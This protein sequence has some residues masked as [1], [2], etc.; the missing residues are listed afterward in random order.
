MFMFVSITSRCSD[1]NSSWSICSSSSSFAGETGVD[2]RTAW[3][4]PVP[5]SDCAREIIEEEEDEDDE[6]SPIELLL[7]DDEE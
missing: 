4:S 1:S 7:E 6:E 5:A 3:R 2:G